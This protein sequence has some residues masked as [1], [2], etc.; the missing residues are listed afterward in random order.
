[1]DVTKV[2]AE[3]IVRAAPPPPKFCERVIKAWN[4]SKLQRR[5]LAYLLEFLN[6]T[7][8]DATALVDQVT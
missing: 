5:E 3:T 2:C 8:V 1:M 7:L 4:E 6:G